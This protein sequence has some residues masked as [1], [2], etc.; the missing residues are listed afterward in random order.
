MT[1]QL[2]ASVVFHKNKLA[3]GR[4]NDLLVKLKDDLINFKN[5][6]KTIPN[7]TKSTLSKN[8]VL[9]GRKTWYS[10]PAS[11]R[12]LKDRINV[13]LT[14]DKELHKESGYP[15]CLPWKKPVFDKSLYYMSYKQFLK[16]YQLTNADVFVIGGSDIY[17]LFLSNA[18]MKPSTLYI[19]EV[20][21]NYKN[22]EKEPD[23]FMNNIQQSYK[24]THVSKK[25]TDEKSGLSYRF[26]TFELTHCHLSEENKYLQLCKDVLNNGKE[27]CDRTG[28][29][30]ISSF[31]HQIEFDISTRIPLLTTKRVPWKACIEELLWFLRGDTDANLLQKK[32][33]NIWNGNTSREFLDSRKLHHYNEGILGPG[34]GWNW[35]FFGATYSQ[36]FADTSTVDRTKVGGVDQIQNVLDL[37]QN[38]PFSRRI[39][40]SAWNPSQLDQVALPPCHMMFQFYVDQINN[41]RYLSCHFIHRSQDLLLGSPF[42]IFSYAVLTYILA[43]KSNMKPLK[44]VMTV[45]DTHI[46]KSHVEAMKT[47]LGREPRP[48][49]KLVINESVQHK[50]FASIDI[51]DFD[52]V[53]YFP[54]PAIK[55][56][57]AI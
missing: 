39:L 47:Q 23:V 43:L 8:V 9:M 45:S 50:D 28:V 38:D 7:G 4:G 3:I 15:K 31:G 27:R 53:G 30:T 22:T 52:I 12:P 6:T 40:V 29:G 14:N 36:A 42:N 37:L 21:H 48:L 20:Q 1:I 44:L 24:L 51:S 11:Q 26:L 46:Y 19:T 5:I 41:E 54:H 49:P 34:Y 17:N 16:F 55:A 2:I 56:D 10:L 35:R 33:V 57:M 13:V 25:Q 32:G 18:H